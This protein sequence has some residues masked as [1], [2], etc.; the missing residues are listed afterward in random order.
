MSDPN[1]PQ[2]GDQQPNP[3]GQ[4]PY[5]GS[6]QPPPPPQQPYGAPQGQPGYSAPQGQPGYGAPQGQPGYGAPQGQPGYGAPQGGQPGYGGPQQ[7]YG[8]Q[9]YGQP[10]GAAPLTP[11]EDKQ[12]AMW[13]HFGGVLGFL[14]SLIIFLVFKDRGGF[15][16]Q[17]SKEALNWQITWIIANIA[18]SIITTILSVSLIFGGGYG[19]GGI[20]ALLSFIAWLPYLANLVFSIIGGVKVNSGQAYRY[21]VNF[22]FIK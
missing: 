5:G 3:N 20:S 2:S 11:A 10:S 6:Q 14:P 13:S 9:P 4:P 18:V 22:R 7:P 21:P 19:Y 8:Q 1:S 12:W 17:E 15:T 16:K